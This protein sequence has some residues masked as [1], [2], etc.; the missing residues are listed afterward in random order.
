MTI[1][2]TLDEKYEGPTTFST[3]VF[4]TNPFY[5]L[6]EQP[7]E[8]TTVRVFKDTDGDG[9]GDSMDNC[10]LVPNPDQTDSDVTM[11]REIYAGSDNNNLYAMDHDGVTLWT[12]PLDAP[13]SSIELADMNNDRIPEIVAA[14]R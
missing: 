8:S 3:T 10:P 14:T 6:D 5:I 9:I 13:V 7:R 4:S 1:P 11:G 12:I 2:F